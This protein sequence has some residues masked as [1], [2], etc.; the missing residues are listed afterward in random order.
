MQNTKTERSN[1]NK[2]RAVKCCK[3]FSNRFWLLSKG[4]QWSSCVVQYCSTKCSSNTF[5][6]GNLSQVQFK[7]KSEHFYLLPPSICHKLQWT[8]WC[9]IRVD[10]TNISMVY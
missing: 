2:N 5:V 6:C 4:N 3:W 9:S 1:S 7:R 8:Q 10:C